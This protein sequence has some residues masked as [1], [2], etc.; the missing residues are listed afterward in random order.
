MRDANEECISY[1]KSKIITL[2][3]KLQGPK[4]L[5]RPAGL[6][7]LQSP[8]GKSGEILN[9]FN[10]LGMLYR[11]DPANP[12][13]LKLY[14]SFQIELEMLPNVFQGEDSWLFLSIGFTIPQQ[15]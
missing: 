9:I 8:A 15:M 1:G 6:G 5:L 11:P 7:T 12:S 14:L 13:C 10:S 3:F 4:D 2:L